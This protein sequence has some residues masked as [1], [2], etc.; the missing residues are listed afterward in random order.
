MTDTD[1]AEQ[2]SIWTA[3]YERIASAL[4]QFGTEDHFG[5]ADYL[6]VDDNYGHRRHTIEIHKL[7]MLDPRL[8]KMLRA[9]LHD[10]PGWE[11]VIAVD[12]PG[13]ENSWPRMGLIIREHEVIDGLRRSYLPSEFQNLVFEGSIPGSGYD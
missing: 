1:Q 13:T 5:N 8:V 7:P 10:L 3:L 6:L 2:E 12:V 9:F 11:I 4:H